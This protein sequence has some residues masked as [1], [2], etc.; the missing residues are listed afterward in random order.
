MDELQLI[1]S[2]G[3]VDKGAYG[4]QPKVWLKEG[5][6]AFQIKHFLGKACV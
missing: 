4:I 2:D 3:E 5:F 1:F 6:N